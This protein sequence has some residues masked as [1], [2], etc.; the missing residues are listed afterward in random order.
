MQS[1]LLFL[2]AMTHQNPLASYTMQTNYWFQKNKVAA[3]IA[4]CIVY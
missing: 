1:G 4:S 3:P 2:T